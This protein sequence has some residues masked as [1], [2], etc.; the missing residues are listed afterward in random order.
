MKLIRYTPHFLVLA[1]VVIAILLLV[2]AL[3]GEVGLTFVMGLV[4]AV[5][6]D[7]FDGVLARRLDVATERLRVA[8]SAVDS[9]LLVC[10]FASLLLTRGEALNAYAA[11]IAWNI[12]AYLLSLLVPLVKFGKL[13]AYH[14]YS[15]KAAGALLL[16]AVVALFTLGDAP[17]LV[18]MALAVWFIR[19]VERILITLILPEIRTDVSSFLAALALR[20]GG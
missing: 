2:D 1:R 8:D 19:H 14:A 6:S 3:D 5:L 16:V 18:W 12:G 11:P 20:Q 7:I 15:A 13:P 4:A 9:V 10:V 17:W